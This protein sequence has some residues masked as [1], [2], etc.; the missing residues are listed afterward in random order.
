MRKRGHCTAESCR[1]KRSMEIAE[2]LTQEAGVQTYVNQT[3]RMV[4]MPMHTMEVIMVSA[5]GKKAQDVS[6]HRL[7]GEAAVPT[8]MRWPL[9]RM[10]T[11]VYWW[12]ALQCERHCSEK[13]RAAAHL[14]EY[15]DMTQ[16]ARHRV[17]ISFPTRKL[18]LSTAMQ[19]IFI[20]SS[21]AACLWM[22]ALTQHVLGPHTATV[23]EGDTRGHEQDNERRNEHPCRVACN[24]E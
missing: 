14:S 1:D 10:Y 19:N 2:R 5:G 15:A 17:A 22:K 13:Q 21:C 20:N 24:S 6:E 23:E 11:G 8:Q 3:H 12:M 9:R 7:A 16:T 18:R 4:T